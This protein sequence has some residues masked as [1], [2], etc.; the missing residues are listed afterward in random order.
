MVTNYQQGK[1]GI[2]IRIESLSGDK[3]LSW[4]RISSGL[5]KFASDLTEKSRIPGDD[6]NGSAQTGQPSSQEL[7]I[8]PHSQ[9]ETDRPSAK[10]KLEPNS[11]SI[12][13]PSLE[14]I[15]VPER[16]WF[17]VEPD[18]N[19]YTTL[20]HDVSTRM[21]ALLRHEQDILREDDGAGES[22]R[23]KRDIKANFPHSVLWS[24]NTWV[25]HLQRGGGRKK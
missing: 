8:E 14:Q 18:P 24:N 5:N 10:A 11:S 13:Q 7:R 22:W 12:Q 20:S 6:D 17:D 21:I 4:V 16:R 2:E 23:L 19:K 25:S 1:L 9:K 15:S 3:S